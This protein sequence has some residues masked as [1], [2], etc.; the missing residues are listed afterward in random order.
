MEGGR[1]DSFEHEVWHEGDRDRVVLICDIWHPELD[2]DAMVLPL[3][4]PTQREAYNA[5]SRGDHLPMRK[6]SDGL[7]WSQHPVRPTDGGGHG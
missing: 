1:D 2:V 6:T 4:S 7:R 5:A 3:L